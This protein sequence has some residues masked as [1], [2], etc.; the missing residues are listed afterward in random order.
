MT[1][2]RL[3]KFIQITLTTIFLI[4][5]MTLVVGIAINGINE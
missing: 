1:T 3:E 4:G 5:F 2:N